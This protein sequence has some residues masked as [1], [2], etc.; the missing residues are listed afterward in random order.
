MLAFT[1]RLG[2]FF[3]LNCLIS[4]G[5]LMGQ[6]QTQTEVIG[7]EI[8]AGEVTYLDLQYVYGGDYTM[9][10]TYSEEE[11]VQKILSHPKL[12]RLNIGGQS[13]TPELMTVIHDQLVDLKELK[14][15]GSIRFNNGDG[16]VYSWESVNWQEISAEMIGALI[17]SHSP[18]ERLDLSLSTVDDAGLAAIGQGATNLTELNLKGANKITDQGLLLLMEKLPSLKFIDISAVSLK[19]PYNNVEIVSASISKEVIQQLRDHGITVSE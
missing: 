18:I 13:I 7:E 17:Q 1:R 12:E 9:G 14:L 4:A 19:Q 5:A 15:L 8:P 11:L 2:Y 3:V 6:T 16:W 10:R